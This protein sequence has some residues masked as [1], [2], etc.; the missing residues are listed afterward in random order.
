MDQQQHEQSLSLASD[1]NDI[2]EKHKEQEIII[3][4][5]KIEIGNSHDKMRMLQEELDKCN[6]EIG[7]VNQENY[8]FKNELNQEKQNHMHHRHLIEVK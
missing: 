6:D 2:K 1:N 5:L 3:N 7:I 4:D 8:D